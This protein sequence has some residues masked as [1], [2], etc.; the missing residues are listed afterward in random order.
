MIQDITY[1][2]EEV[3][4]REF[5]NYLMRVA[6]EQFLQFE[7]EIDKYLRTLTRSK[8]ID[9][10]MLAHLL[11]QDW[12]HSLMEKP[13]FI[14]NDL[15]LL[16]EYSLL[17]Y[18]LNGNPCIYARNIESGELIAKLIEH[19]STPVFHLIPSALLLISADTVKTQGETVDIL[20]W[21]LQEDLIDKFSI[22]PPWIS[23]IFF[24]KFLLFIAFDKLMINQ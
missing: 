22:R 16:A 17:F 5:K 18:T 15:A 10:A 2:G 14:V 6:Y 20:V 23:N 8:T 9:Y 13:Y 7:K 24:M 21:R 19:R 4:L 3:G 1:Q 12:G 11:G